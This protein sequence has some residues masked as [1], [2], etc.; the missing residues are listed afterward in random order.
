MVLA[1]RE[2]SARDEHGTPHI[3]DWLAL[4]EVEKYA[5]STT[6]APRPYAKVIMS[7]EAAESRIEAA[8]L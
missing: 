4:R 8:N 3:F 5:E 6:E 7:D 1:G 2:E